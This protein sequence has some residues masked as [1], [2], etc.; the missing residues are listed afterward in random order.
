MIRVVETAFGILLF[1]GMVVAVDCT[2]HPSHDAAFGGAGASVTGAWQSP[3]TCKPTTRPQMLCDRV[4]KDHAHECAICVEKS[5][6]T[7]TGVYCAV[8][9]DDP[10]CVP[11]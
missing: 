7:Q 2:K 4:T 11:R 10:A 3:S 9:C 6:Q 8:S 1:S 5:C